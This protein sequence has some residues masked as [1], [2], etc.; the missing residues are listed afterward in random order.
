MSSAFFDLDQVPPAYRQ[1]CG[2]INAMRA[3]TTELKEL[4]K[5]LG[6]HFRATGEGEKAAIAANVAAI[7]NMLETMRMVDRLM[8]E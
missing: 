8:G 2:E 6:T 3:R 4:G 7:N 1:A 5:E